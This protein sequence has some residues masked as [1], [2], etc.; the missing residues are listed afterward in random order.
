M[1]AMGR[2]ERLAVGEPAQQRRGRVHQIIHRQQQGGGELLMIGQLQQAPAEQQADRQAADVAEKDLRHRT[3][4]RRETRASRRRAPRQTMV[5]GAGNSPSDPSTTI[6]PVIGTTS[7]TVIQSSPSMKLTR[8]TNQRPASRSRPRS[9]QSGQGGTIRRSPGA[10]KM[11]APT[12][13]ACSNSRGST[14]IDLR[15]SAKPTS[16]DEQRGCENRDG[17]I[18]R[19]G[20]GVGRQ[21]CRRPPA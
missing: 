2:P 11:I 3:V 10:V 8:F 18:Q 14:G 16:G 19:H 1:R 12:A 17:D 20:A 6:A 13:N 4:E 7:A 15:S 9:I 21:G 5:A